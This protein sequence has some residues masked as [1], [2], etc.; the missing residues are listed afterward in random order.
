MRVVSLILLF[1]T[2]FYSLGLVLANSSEVEVNLLFVQV[3]AMNLGL[4]LIICLVLGVLTGLLLAVQAFRVIQN[5]WELKRLH[6][7]HKQLQTKLDEAQQKIELYQQQ[8]QASHLAPVVNEYDETQTVDET[9]I[10]KPN[11]EK[12]P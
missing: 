4:L 1:I 12:S 6:K 11:L 9:L 5:K 10:T 8:M 7:E 3:P 2:F